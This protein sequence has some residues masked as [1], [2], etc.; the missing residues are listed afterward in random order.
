[1]HHSFDWLKVFPVRAG[2]CILAVVLSTACSS[3]K[4]GSGLP[5]GVTAGGECA[6]CHGSTDN[7]APPKSLAGKTDTAELSVG[8]H[9]AH[10]VAGQYSQPVACGECHKVP[11]EVDDEGHVDGLPAD[12]TWGPLASA[13]GAKPDWDRAAGTCSATYCHGGTLEGGSIKDF[14]WTTGTG[15]TPLPSG[16]CGACHGFPPPSP[17]PQVSSCQ[18]CHGGTVGPDGKI[19]VEGGKHINGSVDASGQ[20]PDGYASPDQHGKDFEA[21]GLQA[22]TPCHGDDLA[23]GAGGGVSCQ[24]CHPGF[25]THC[26][27]CHGGTDNAT[28]APPEDLAGSTSTAST[29]VGRHTVHLAASSDWHKIVGCSECHAVPDSIFTPGHVDGG[30]AEITWGDLA[31]MYGVAPEWKDGTCSST[32]CHGGGTVTGGANENPTWA[33]EGPA[34]AQCNGCHGMPPEPPHSTGTEC[35]ICHG[36]VIGP[37]NAFI[38]PELHIDGTA[39]HQKYHPETWKDPAIHGASLKKEGPSKCAT[40]H[41]DDLAGG[42]SNVSCDKCHPGW[43]SS[44]TFCHGGLDNQTGAPPA[45]SAGNTD[46]SKAGVGAHTAHVAL[47]SDPPTDKEF[48]CSQCHPTYA[49]ALSAG[50]I[51][52]KVAVEFGGL[53]KTDGSDPQ[54]DGTSCSTVYCHGASLSGGSETVPAWTDETGVASACGA[55]HGT[56]PDAPHPQMDDCSL[57]HA[58]TVGEDGA[59]IPGGTKHINGSIE[60]GESPHPDEYEDPGKH[61]ADFDAGGV[62]ACSACH[63]TDLK[64]GPSGKSCDE[65]HPGFQE[66]CTFCHGGTDNQTGA[67]PEDVAGGTSMALTGVGRHTAHMTSGS[68]WHKDVACAECHAVPSDVLTPGH[69]DGGA[70]EVEFGDLAGADDAKPVWAAGTCSATYCHGGTLSGGAQADPA[71]AGNGPTP[72]A[73]DACHGMPPAP[74]HPGS[75]DCFVCHSAVVGPGNVIADPALHINGKTESSK[76]HPAGWASPTA[77][78]KEFKTKFAATCTPCHG[79]DLKGGGTG[80]SCEGCHPGWNTNCTFCHGG[81]DNATGAPPFDSEG[82]SD[83]TMVGVG[84]HTA[85][86]ALQTNP[87]T[88]K[89]FACNACHPAYTDALSTGHVDGVVTVSFGGLAKTDG[90]DPKWDGTSCSGVYCHGA[91]DLGDFATPTWTDVSG[92]A[93]KCGACHGVPPG[94]EHPDSTN[95]SGCHSSTAGPNQT[96]KAGSTT[97]I[98]GNGDF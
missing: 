89:A 81:K 23:G 35:W 38:A 53:A 18:A 37:N 78:G 12:I 72:L 13:D 9:Q 84:A 96:I 80:V 94:G 67:P 93:G 52:Q 76:Y 16:S 92:N 32:Y 7:P 5:D 66:S 8:V 57:C 61:G 95:C 62:A 83:R 36:N 30:K 79:A 22:C 17:H 47:Q 11:S 58:A 55:C 3:D 54:W 46:R 85:H 49:D 74:P 24:T 40:C 28:G 86:V 56:P 82:N 25:E 27:F 4:L 64:G 43:K 20:H 75:T 77:H 73:C 34:P 2:T 91:F 21:N 48:A 68:A 31:N 70:G 65:C 87:V 26:T 33:G 45:D 42:F 10:L 15:A 71:W 1:M 98:N 51:N 97:H 59:L 39:Q 50:H 14:Q 19:L 6:S 69:V 60:A 90:A 88:D 44:C 41:G 29:G 63:G